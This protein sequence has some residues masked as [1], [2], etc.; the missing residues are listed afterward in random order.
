MVTQLAKALGAAK[1]LGIVG[2]VAAYAGARTLGGALLAADG[3]L[4]LGVVVVSLRVMRA[5]QRSV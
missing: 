4:L 5:Q 1:A 3:V 2:V